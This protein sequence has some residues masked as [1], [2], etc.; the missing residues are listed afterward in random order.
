VPQI[1]EFLLYYYGTGVLKCENKKAIFI[2]LDKI[3]EK[4]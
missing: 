3:I 2:N 1:V 4:T